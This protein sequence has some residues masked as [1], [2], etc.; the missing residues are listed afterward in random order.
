MSLEQD[1]RKLSQAPL[2]GELEAEARRILSFSGETRNLRTGEVLFQK[3]EPSDG[4]FVVFSGSV[5]L[6]PGSAAD[7]ELH[8]I[9][10]YAL[11]GEIAL[12]SQ[13]ERT[14]TARAC[15]PTVVMK[16]SR[17]LFHRVLKEF[18]QSAVRLRELIATRLA[19]YSIYLEGARTT[20]FTVA[21]ADEQV[22]D[23]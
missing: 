9:Y 21:T 17:H 10:P 16:I 6:D 5:S 22:R 4:G 8:V 23:P 1:L 20:A 15:E 19:E 18:P 11:I 2:L 12:I 7:G 3:G 13:T 14:F